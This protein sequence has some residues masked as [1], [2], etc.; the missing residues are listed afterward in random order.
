MRPTGPTLVEV[1]RGLVGAAELP[2]RRRHVIRH[3]DLAVVR[4]HLERQ[5]LSGEIG[6][7]LPVLPPVAAHGEPVRAGS[8]DPSRGH[9]AGAGDVGNG[10]KLEVVVPADAEPDPAGPLARDPAVVDRDDSGLVHA[11]G[12]PGRL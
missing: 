7:A 10:H 6:P 2:V 4:L 11:D 12:L 5:G 8:H 9:R 3:N 1:D